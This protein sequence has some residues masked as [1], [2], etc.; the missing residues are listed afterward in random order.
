[1]SSISF[2]DSIGAATLQSP[3]NAPG[4][5]FAN[6]VPDVQDIGSPEVAV[7]TGISY[8]FILRTD[9]C[10]SFEVPYLTEAQ[11]AVAH[12]L[13]RW[14]MQGG[15]VTVTTNDNDSNTY[16]AY[17]RAGTV[18]SIELTDRALME[19]TMSLELKNSAAAPMTVNYSP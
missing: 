2:T 6:W 3:M 5:R 9:Y 16:T 15:A 13:K 8:L 12:R 7:G 17:L 4:N 19:Y 1:M 18:P 14:L 10:A 11:L